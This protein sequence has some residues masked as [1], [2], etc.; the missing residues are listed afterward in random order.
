MAEEY[1]YE[2]KIPKERIAVLIGKSGETKTELESQT[3]SKI[4]VDS[5]EGDVVIS[6]NDS[7]GLFVLKDIVKAVG[8]GFNPEIAMRLLK[9]DYVLEMLNLSDFVKSQDQQLRLR[10]RVIG[11]GG[12]ARATIEEFTNTAISVYGKTIAIIGFCDDVAISKKA[13]ESLLTGSPHASVYKWLE[14]HRKQTK[15]KEMVEF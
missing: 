12:K 4:E 1:S 9:Q 15:F 5:K 10:G 14:K 8:R 13:V 3:K 7:L 6:G 2:L 11:K